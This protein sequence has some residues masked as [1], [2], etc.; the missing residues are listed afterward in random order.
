M[1]KSPVIFFSILWSCAAI[2]VIQLLFSVSAKDKTKYHQYIS[3][4][5]ESGKEALSEPMTQHK[6]NV[7]KEFF[8]DKGSGYLEAAKAKWI[9]DPKKNIYV[10]KLNFIKGVITQEETKKNITADKGI[11]DYK[12]QT[13]TLYDTTT[14]FHYETE[15]G[16]TASISSHSKQAV[17]TLDP[18]NTSFSLQKTNGKIVQ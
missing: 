9:F 8:S 17:F 16:K 14:S 15:N 5:L 12:N 13:L 6:Q 10:E 3:F 4:V 2:L 18:K 11:Y 7:K 1:L